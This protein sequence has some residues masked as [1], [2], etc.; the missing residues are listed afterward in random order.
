M[1]AK[2]MQ[3]K[4]VLGILCHPD[5]E[6]LFGWPIFQAQDIEKYLVIICDDYARKG[7]CRRNALRK[8]CKQENINLIQCHSYDNNFYTL[9]TRRAE[10][11]LNFVIDEINF[12][13]SKAIDEVNPDFIFTHN[14]VGEYGHGSHRL[15]FE[16][17]SQHPKVNNLLITDVCQESNHRSHKEI[18]QF[19]NDIF[20]KK[21]FRRNYKL[22]MFFYL[23]CKAIYDA[24][25]AWTWNKEPI[26]NCNLYLLKEK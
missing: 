8:V 18:P 5:D 17:V 7:S 12:I 26:K 9:P 10:I 16:L 2:D 25:R 14:P 15:L 20:Y 11:L 13:I 1:N 21:V 4:K 23:R 6:V 3:K 19:I 22:D 24:Y